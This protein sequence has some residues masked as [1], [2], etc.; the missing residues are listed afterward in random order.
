MKMILINRDKWD[1][2]KYLLTKPVDK[3][4]AVLEEY[5]GY[6]TIIQYSQKYDN[7]H[8]V[9]VKTDNLDKAYELV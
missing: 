7:L 2:M 5:N 3:Y 1:V 9:S 8:I 4:Y 6:S